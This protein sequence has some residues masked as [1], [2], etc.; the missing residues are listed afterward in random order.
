MTAQ[1]LKG[2]FWKSEKDDE[3]GYAIVAHNLKEAKSIG[4][5]NNAS[6]CGNNNEWIEQYCRRNKE[7]NVEGISEPCVLDYKEGL[8]RGGYAYV[9]MEDCEICGEEDILRYAFG[10]CICSSCKDKLSDKEAGK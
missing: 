5:N 7:L 6:E 1:P 2:Y 4:W 9:E 3:H 8:K 10:K